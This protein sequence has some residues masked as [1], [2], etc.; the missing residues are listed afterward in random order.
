MNK[1][2]VYPS[3]EETTSTIHAVPELHTEGPTHGPYQGRR[4]RCLE[5]YRQGVKF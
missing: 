4:V 3:F 1:S 5:S 2:T